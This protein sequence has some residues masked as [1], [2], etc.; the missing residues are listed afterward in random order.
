[1]ST[2]QSCPSH[3]SSPSESLEVPLEIPSAPLLLHPP[4]YLPPSCYLVIQ[5]RCCFSLNIKHSTSLPCSLNRKQVCLLRTQLLFLLIFSVKPSISP[6]PSDFPSIVH[7][8]KSFSFCSLNISNLYSRINF[9]LLSIRK[10]L[11]I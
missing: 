4:D 8:F 10:T 11:Y 7:V 5:S 9:N 3:A 6:S 2:Q 1:M